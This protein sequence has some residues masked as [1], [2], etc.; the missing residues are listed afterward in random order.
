LRGII[1]ECWALL[2]ERA[3]ARRLIVEQHVPPRCDTTGDADKLRI[4]L[5][6]LLDN[7]VSHADEG[8]R[9]RIEV[10]AAEQR[11][12]VR[13]TN[14]GSQITAVDVPRLFERFWRGD[15]SRTDAGLHCGLGLSL[16][17]RLTTLL[18]G[19]IVAESITGGDF[20]VRLILPR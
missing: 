7:A 10:E 11:V 1:D 16:C 3:S 20:C 19:E 2:R 9:I 4:I 6:N 13:I 12:T 8:G 5:Q 17:Q 15:E 18:G 14:S